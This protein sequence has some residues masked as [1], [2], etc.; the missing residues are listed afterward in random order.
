LFPNPASDAVTIKTESATGKV[1]IYSM[2]G[3]LVM[4][5][6]INASSTTLD[7]SRLGQG[8]YQLKYSNGEQ[9]QQAKIVVQ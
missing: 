9:L 7:V 8:V 3:Q 1:A 2:Q 6:A 5:K 4:Q